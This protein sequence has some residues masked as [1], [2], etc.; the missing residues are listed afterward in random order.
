VA[1]MLLLLLLL[2]LM[3]MM[4]LMIYTADRP[5]VIAVRTS[6]QWSP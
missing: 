3:M 2:L 1:A 5:V 6:S 4:I